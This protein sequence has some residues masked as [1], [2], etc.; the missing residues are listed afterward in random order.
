MGCMI[1]PTP[2][3]ISALALRVLLNEAERQCRGAGL[4]L[5][6]AKITCAQVLEIRASKLPTLVLAIRYGICPSYCHQVR[7][8]VKRQ[9]VQPEK[10]VV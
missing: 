4:P 6:R 10:G 1:E 3:P 8:A 5:R 9:L 2:R 7:N